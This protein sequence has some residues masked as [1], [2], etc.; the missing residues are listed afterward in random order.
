[1]EKL[2]ETLHHYFLYLG[3]NIFLFCGTISLFAYPS[4]GL[5]RDLQHYSDSLKSPDSIC[6]S[7]VRIECRKKTKLRIIQRELSIRK[8]QKIA[9]TNLAQYLEKESHKLFNTDLFVVTDVIPV[10]SGRD[11]IEVVVSLVE[12]WYFYPIPILELG[13]RNFNEWASSYHFDPSW[14]DWGIRFRQQNFRGRNE[15]VRLHFQNGFTQKLMLL[16]NIPYINRKQTTG[17]RF[18][19]MYAGNRNLPYK[20]DSQGERLVLQSTSKQLRRWEFATRL[21]KRSHFYNTHFFT[22]GFRSNH[23]T[24]TIQE[25]NPDYFLEGRTQQRYFFLKYDFNRNLTDASG[26][27]LKGMLLRLS[28]EQKGLGFFNDLNKFEVR[29]LYAKFVPLRKKWFWASSFRGLFSFPDRQPY[30]DQA[31]FGYFQN[32]LRGY[33]PYTIDVTRYALSRNTLRY[34]LCSTRKQLGKF[35]PLEQFRT[36]PVAL[37]F[38]I[39]G[40]FGHTE[41]GSMHPN[42]SPYADRFLWGTGV[43]LDLVTFYNAVFRLEFSV[44]REGENR[45]AFGVKSDF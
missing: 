1:M 20:T 2:V 35:M 6:I 15:D 19:I 8:G 38:K 34:Q 18:K 30:N 7:E 22:L 45:L 41:S 24:D 36:M 42:P 31:S 11:S 27:P 17:I 21:S 9:K 29:A 44:N 3:L 16:Y 33:E 10:P 23:I 26:Y 40:D 5:I 4:Q 12:K 39:F 43:G 13:A 14:I 25:L 32:T 37:Y 28:F